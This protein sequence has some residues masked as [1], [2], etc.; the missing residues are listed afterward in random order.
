MSAKFNLFRRQYR[1]GKVDKDDLQEAV[2]KGLITENQK[3]EII[4]SVSEQQDIEAHQIQ[5]T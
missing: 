5:R 1:R 3:E 2:D 4:N